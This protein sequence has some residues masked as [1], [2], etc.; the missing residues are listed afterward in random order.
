MKDAIHHNLNTVMGMKDKDRLGVV[1]IW[2]LIT[3]T[4]F[5]G[6]EKLKNIAR[7]LI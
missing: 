3:C 7:F 2:Q 5:R 4:T 1:R 6:S